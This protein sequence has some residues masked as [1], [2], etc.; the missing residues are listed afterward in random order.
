MLLNIV[1]FLCFALAKSSFIYDGLNEISFNSDCHINV[2]FDSMF[3]KAIEEFSAQYWKSE[4][5]RGGMTL[6][7]TNEYIEFTLFNSSYPTG[8]QSDWFCISFVIYVENE[9]R[10]RVLTNVVNAD[11]FDHVDK[12]VF[13]NSYQ[14]END[15][16]ANFPVQRIHYGNFFTITQN[17]ELKISKY[18]IHNI[19]D[20]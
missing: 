15:F 2:I 12:V 13:V 7:T 19:F 20:Q 3:R 6:M 4:G 8:V 9:D 1:I 11:Y 18:V 14:S 17:E 16:L 10:I 5:K